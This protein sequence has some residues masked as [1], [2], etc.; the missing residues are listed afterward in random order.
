MTDQN[1]MADV[2]H[3]GEI[4]LV[5]DVEDNTSPDSPTENNDTDNTQNSDGDDTNDQQDDTGDDST[6]D[7]TDDNVPFHEHPRWKQRETE[8]QKRFNEQE[9]RNQDAIKSIREEFDKD[10]KSNA[11]QTEIPSWFGGDQAQW[12]SYRKHQ[13]GLIKEAEDRAVKSFEDKESAKS[14]ALTEATDYMKSEV[15][16]IQGDKELNPDGKKID[17]NK[18]IKVVMDND[19][20]DSKGRWNYRAGWNMLRG[21]STKTSD[22]GDRKK[23]AGATTSGPKGEAKPTAFKTTD[24]FKSKRPW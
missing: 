22:K 14:K 20:V 21:M 11:E 4:T 16:T 1:S 8:W 24:D 2:P 23:I 17:S 9:T 13:D 12:D 3:E 6:D 18:L 19:L 5:P 10:I 7:S 15:S